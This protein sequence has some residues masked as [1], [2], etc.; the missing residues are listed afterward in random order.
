[1]IRWANNQAPAHDLA[2][3]LKFVQC[4]LKGKSKRTLIKG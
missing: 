4:E 1:M 3:D 2:H